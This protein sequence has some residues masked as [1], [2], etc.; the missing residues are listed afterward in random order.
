MEEIIRG[1]A[2]KAAEAGVTIVGGHSI[3]D[4][5]PKYGLAV[6]GFVEPGK[7]SAKSGTKPVTG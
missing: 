1:G 6:T 3:T 7:M 2:E 5:A 4:S